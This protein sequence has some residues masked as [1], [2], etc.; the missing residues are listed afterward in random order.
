MEEE[1]VLRRVKKVVATQLNVDQ[2]RM[3][4]EASFTGDLGADELDMAE[5][6]IA[7][8]EKFGIEVPNDDAKEITT[9]GKAVQLIAPWI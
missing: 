8:E 3:T 7:L 4:M 2:G 5:L 6:V 9:A 1:E